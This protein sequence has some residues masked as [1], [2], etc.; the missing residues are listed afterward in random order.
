M[1]FSTS[2]ATIK[3]AW[4]ITFRKSRS[5]TEKYLTVVLLLR[6]IA[7]QVHFLYSL[8]TCT[9]MYLLQVSYTVGRRY[10]AVM[11]HLCTYIYV[12]SCSDFLSECVHSVRLRLEPASVLKP[13]INR[14]CLPGN[15]SQMS[16]GETRRPHDPHKTLNDGRG[17]GGDKTLNTSPCPTPRF[18]WLTMGHLGWNFFPSLQVRNA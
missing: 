18:S 1:Y 10:L 8:E 17:G 9:S 12:Q 16:A 4:P 13:C 14:M 6:G 5:R 7:K 3:Y 11:R 2:F 15:S